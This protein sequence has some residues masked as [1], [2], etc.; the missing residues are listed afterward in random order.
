MKR[1]EGKKPEDGI[2]NRQAALEALRGKYNSHTKGARRACHEK[3][4]TARMD[5]GQDH[6]DFI[7]WD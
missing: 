2:G 1:F 3:L 7:F 5:P 6:D 4:V